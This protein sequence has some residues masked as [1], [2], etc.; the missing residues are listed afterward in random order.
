MVLW[1]FKFVMFIW[2]F[3]LAETSGTTHYVAAYQLPYVRAW[4]RVRIRVRFGFRVRV[5]VRVTV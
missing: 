3:K 5:R 2:R 4:A 1:T